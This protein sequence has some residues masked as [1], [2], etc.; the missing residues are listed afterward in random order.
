MSESRTDLPDVELALTTWAR[1]TFDATVCTELPSN[2]ET[3]LPLI[4]V[5]Q[6][7]GSGTRF[8]VDPLIDVDVYAANYAA[9]RDLARAVYRA[10]VLLRGIV[11]DVVVRDVRVSS[12]PSR[13]PY[14]NSALRRVGATY[15]VSARPNLYG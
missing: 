11:D 10:L 15:S 1:A 3:V 2:L 4:Q 12:L 5:E 7:A 9:A 14:D 8:S 6:I 13:R